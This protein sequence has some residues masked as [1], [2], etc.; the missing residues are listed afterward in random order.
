MNVK[1]FMSRERFKKLVKKNN[2]NKRSNLKRDAPLPLI[3]KMIV[4]F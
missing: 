4:V 1:N 3:K 2:K